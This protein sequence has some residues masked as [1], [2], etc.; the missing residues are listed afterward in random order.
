VLRLGCSSV[1][2]HLPSLSEAWGLIPSTAEKKDLFRMLQSNYHSLLSLAAEWTMAP[3]SA[4]K[5]EG[6]R[7]RGSV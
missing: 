5:G 7:L 4:G 3:L 2:E 6:K 1:V